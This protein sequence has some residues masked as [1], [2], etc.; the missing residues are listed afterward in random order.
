[1]QYRALS[2]RISL[3]RT[4]EIAS[5]D[6]SSTQIPKP[7]ASMVLQ[8]SLA[9]KSHYSFSLSSEPLLTQIFSLSLTFSGHGCFNAP[10]VTANCTVDCDP[11]KCKRITN[12]ELQRADP[13][14]WPCCVFRHMSD[15]QL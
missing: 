9:E 8:V 7:K 11:E 15:V 10:S 14:E 3:P 1:M 5:S 4:F 6:C 13:N 2:C 12:A